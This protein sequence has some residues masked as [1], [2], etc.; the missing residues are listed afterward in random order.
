MAVL[1]GFVE[2]YAVGRRTLV[3]HE[4]G[5]APSTLLTLDCLLG[6]LFSTFVSR[7]SNRLLS[8]RVPV[9]ADWTSDEVWNCT[10]CCSTFLC[11][12]LSIM[13]SSCRYWNRRGTFTWNHLTV[14]LMLSVKAYRSDILRTGC[15]LL[16]FRRSVYTTGSL[17]IV[18]IRTLRDRWSRSLIHL[19]IL[20]NA[21][22]L[23]S[24]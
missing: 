15:S 11:M 23:V 22:V 1:I 14:R 20:N 7:D 21:F 6:L 24:V 13:A 10:T 2:D 9:L 19:I 5:D 18:R 12:R 16:I 17:S 8:V 3:E 4:L